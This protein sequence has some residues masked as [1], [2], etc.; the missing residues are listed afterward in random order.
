MVDIGS[1]PSNQKCTAAQPDRLFA[2]NYRSK[3]FGP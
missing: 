3:L 1:Y 2:R